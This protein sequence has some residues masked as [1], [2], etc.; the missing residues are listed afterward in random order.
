MTGRMSYEELEAAYH[1]LQRQNAV[2]KSEKNRVGLSFRRIPETGS[3]IQALR[4]QRFPYLTRVP[5]LSYSLSERRID[6]GEAGREESQATDGN[7]SLIEADNLAALTALQLTHRG[8]VDVIYIDPPY[9]TGSKDFVYNDAR[10]SKLSDVT[11]AEGQS[12]S[13]E[14]YELTLDGNVRSVGKDDPERHSL[15]L[16]FMEKRLWLARHLLSDAGVIMVAIDDNEQARLK[17]LM[18]SI[19]GEDNFIANVIWQGN[20]K[21]DSRFVSVG[22]DYMLIYMKNKSALPSTVKWR[23]KKPEVPLLLSKAEEIWKTLETEEPDVSPDER[24]VKATERFKTWREKQKGNPLAS[25]SGHYNRIDSEGRVYSLSDISWPG[26]GGGQRYEI[27][28]PVTGNP[29]PVPTN[30]WR[31]TR[32]RMNEELRQGNVHFAAEDTRLPYRKT[33]LHDIDSAV[34]EAVF[35]QNRGTATGIIKSI[36]GSREFDYPK[37]VNVIAEWIRYVSRDKKDATVLDFFAGSGTT[38]QAVMELNAEDGGTRNCILVTHGDEN[39]KNIAQDITAVRLKRVLSGKDWAD[40]KKHAPLPGELTYYRLDF[41]SP[42]K[43][44]LEMTGELRGHFA[45]YVSLECSATLA[46]E[47]P[48][49]EGVTLLTSS[50]KNVLVVDDDFLLCDPAMVEALT[51]LH[52]PERENL[53]YLPVEDAHAYY[54]DFDWAARSYPVDGIRSH[55]SLVELMKNNK[56]LLPVPGAGKG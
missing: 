39:G 52:D 51:T 50:G 3:H 47:Q 53:L 19:Y 21:N 16:S 54:P 11:D 14:D 5:S 24:A 13:I 33:Y 27:L 15:W 49:T 32:D 56:T 1:A 44:E 2:L 7:V 18:D 55:M 12:L 23:E 43:S 22:H 40:G 8:R 38:G 36:F 45:G 4:D 29:V 30:G 17:V 35:S 34:K 10:T 28:H 37:N 42:F 25:G 9:N 46:P 20:R 31:Y 41:T 26:S 48:D 6:D